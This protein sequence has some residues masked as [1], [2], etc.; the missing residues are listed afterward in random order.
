MRRNVARHWNNVRETCGLFWPAARFVRRRVTPALAREEIRRALDARQRTFLDLIRDRVYGRD[1]SPYL[2]LLRNAGCDYADLERHVRAHG[3]EKTLEKLAGEGVYLT[4]EEFK[5]KRVVAR[6]RLAFRAAP[7][8]FALSSPSAVFR[9]QS[10]G[11]SNPAVTT[12]LSFA[13][14][15]ARSFAVC[16]FF[17]AH[18]LFSYC[19]AMYDA[20]LPASGGINNLLMYHRVGAN[21]ER[22]FARAVPDDN[23]R[24]YLA[25]YTIALAAKIAGAG[26]PLPER[27]GTGE[28]R[29]IV[30]WIERRRREGRR[31][32]LT[33]AASSAVRVARKALELGIGLDGA[34]FVCSGEP[35]TEGK[36]EIVE[37][38]GAR[39]ATRYA[40]GGSVNIG[41]G[42]ADPAATDEVHVNDYLLALISHARPTAPH[43]S[44][45][46]PLLCTTIHPNAPRLLFNVESGD[47]GTLMRRDC[48][49]ALE[50]S[51]LG[52]HLHG[53]RS[54][55]KFTS[56][57]ANYNYADLYELMEKILPHEFGGGPG[58]YQ[59]REEEDESGQTRI[60]LIVDPAVGAVDEA[61]ILFRLRQAL[62][63][64][65]WTAELWADAGTLR[66]KRETPHASARGKIL[67]LHIAGQT[68]RLDTAHRRKL[69]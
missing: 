30:E 2:K 32:C 27:T 58:D 60:A 69:D 47:Y 18:G 64:R 34:K 7:D 35:L 15:A 49:C 41:F 1:D 44:H 26:F 14:L 36:R 25:T 9:I 56:E 51:G 66:L 10:S 61:A 33:A 65:S 39:A 3:V 42:C 20:V 68:T 6:G 59:L 16:T 62:G 21:V 8:D 54:F 38:T 52:L 53:I 28:A 57:G 5:G 37:R 63:S 46:R 19:H 50:K 23:T 55:E 67:P 17:E 22:W 48:G 45:I 24:H 4:S 13:W 43:L 12:Q 31:C 40:Y 11:T 29:R